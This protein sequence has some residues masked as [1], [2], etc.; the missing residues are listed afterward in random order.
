MGKLYCDDVGEF[1]ECVG[2]KIEKSIWSMKNTQ[3]VIA[4]I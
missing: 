3:S 2:Y 4:K 1:K